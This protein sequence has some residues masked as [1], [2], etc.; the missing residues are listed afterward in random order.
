VNRW[1]TDDIMYPAEAIIAALPH[2]DLADA[3]GD[4]LVNQWLTAAVALGR[5]ELAALLHARDRAL[6][7]NASE[8]RS[9]EIL[10]RTPFDLDAMIARHAV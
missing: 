1:V 2:F 7:M 8:D 4:T 10:S 9:I 3:P 5:P 6:P